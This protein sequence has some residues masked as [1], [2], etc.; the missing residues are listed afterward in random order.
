MEIKNLKKAAER[1]LRAVAAKERIVLYG[2]SDPDGVSCVLILEETIKLLGGKKSKVYFPDRESEGYGI[3]RGALRV[4][5]QY[6]PALLITLDCGI[7]NI[8]ETEAA[9]KMGFEVM[10]IDHH[11]SLARVPR[12]SIIVDPKQKGDEFSFKELACA[13][14]TYKLAQNI[15]G[16]A[17]KQ[18]DPEHFLELVAL[19]TIADQMPVEKDNEK[20]I[21]EG[22]EALK[23]TKRVAFKEL[24]KLT[25]YTHGGYGEFREKLLPAL[26]VWSARRHINPIYE[27]LTETSA[28]KAK[29][30][31]QDFLRKSRERKKELQNI[32]QEADARVAFSQ[33][34]IIFE[35]DSLWPLVFT[36]AMAS[37]LCKKYKK[38]TFLYKEG[39]TESPGASRSPKGIDVVEMMDKCKKFMITYGGHPQAGGFRAKNKNLEELKGCLIDY[40]KNT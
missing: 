38:P 35:G 7:T 9:K 1:I 27:F 16:L 24:I 2:D 14:I 3:N 25:G 12:A 21:R 28:A 32:Y 36:G 5:K 13:G 22:L 18:W 6:A 23:Y 17:Q 15:L 31:G 30:L 8:E 29:S 10:I 4:L 37:R 40:F 33:E 20:L 19:A 11:K 34:P 26:N 39:N